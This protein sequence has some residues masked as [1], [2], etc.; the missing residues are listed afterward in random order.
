VVLDNPY[1]YPKIS[2]GEKIYFWVNDE[3][4]AYTIKNNFI[5]AFED[6]ERGLDGTSIQ[7]HPWGSPV[8][9]AFDSE[10]FNHLEPQQAVWL[11]GN[12]NVTAVTST[13]EW[14]STLWDENANITVTIDSANVEYSDVST[15]NLNVA[16]NLGVVAGDAILVANISGSPNATVI[17]SSVAANVIT[18][19]P[20]YSESLDISNVFVQ[21]NTVNVSFTTYGVSSH[22]WD[23]TTSTSVTVNST[24][25]L[26]DVGN[27]DLSG[28]TQTIMR[29]LH[30]L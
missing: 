24:I 12:A 25:S 15:A 11:E 14:E 17:V 22:A 3:K 27:L 18:V 6:I 7:Q 16:S 23:A 21:G 28:N 1:F 29:F 26:T 8:Y 4:M 30:R 20:N 2:E 5:D 19:V 9:A 10:Y 13:S